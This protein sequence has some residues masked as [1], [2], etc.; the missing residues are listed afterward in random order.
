MIKINNVI[1][2]KNKKRIIESIKKDKYNNV[3]I[4]F[5]EVI[6]GIYLDDLN[7]IGYKILK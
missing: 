6:Q 4:S 3:F 7:K 2:F 1:L 5:K